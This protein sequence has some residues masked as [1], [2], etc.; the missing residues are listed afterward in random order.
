MPIPSIIAVAIGDPANSRLITDMNQLR[1]VR[2]YITG[3]VFYLSEQDYTIGTDYTIDYRECYEGTEDFTGADIAGTNNIIFCMSTPV[4]RK[5]V[6]FTSQVPIVGVFSDYKGEKFNQTNNVCGV[7]ANRI[8]NAKDYYDKFV[9]AASNL[10]AIY[11]LHRPKNTASEQSLANHKKAHPTV[12]LPELDVT[13]AAGNDPRQDI[14]N[15]IN[16]ATNNSGLLVLPVDLFFGA[17]DTI[18]STAKSKSMPVFW[19]LSDWVPPG[20]VGYGVSQYDSGQ[21][22][23]QQVQYILDNP[24]NIPPDPYRFTS[25]GTPRWVASQAAAK[26][27]SFAN[28]KLALQQQNGLLII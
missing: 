9:D 17:A 10:P 12:K 18:N 5:A 4:V 14:Q 6:A 3:L 19:P 16:S 22:M 20:L 23:G 26:V 8:D 25:A 2:P 28:N 15:A 24:K 27:L 11:I 13:T 21:S 1:G 7:T